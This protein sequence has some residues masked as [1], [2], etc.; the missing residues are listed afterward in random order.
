[1]DVKPAYGNAPCFYRWLRAM[2]EPETGSNLR[3]IWW[4]LS[5]MPRGCAT[6]FQVLEAVKRLEAFPEP[7]KAAEEL[8]MRYCRE[9]KMVILTQMT[10]V[11]TSFDELTHLYETK[12][13]GNEDPGAQ[14]FREPI[15][16][17]NKLRT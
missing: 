8:W 2:P 17:I 9:N 5:D 13:G 7:E 1:M 6:Y 10:R 15:S 3:R 14:K 16:L 4:S 11:M 12:C